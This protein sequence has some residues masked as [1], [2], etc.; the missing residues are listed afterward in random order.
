LP[1][2]FRPGGS[3]ARNAGK[4]AFAALA[5][6]CLTAEAPSPT[7][8][9][10]ANLAYEFVVHGRLPGPA[11]WK[12]SRGDSK[13]FVLGMP[14]ALPKGMTW[15]TSVLER[16]LKGANELIGRPQVRAG[17]G[18]LFSILK[19]RTSQPMEAQLSPSLRARLTAAEARIG[20]N[21]DAYSH[22]TPVVAGLQLVGDYRKSVALDSAEPGATIERLARREGIRV[23]PAGA[24]N[25]GALL[26]TITPELSAL[27]EI[28][29][30][31]ALDEVDA[32]PEQIRVAAE[33]W[34]KGDPRA[35]LSASR[36]YEKCVNAMPEGADLARRAMTDTAASIE[37]ALAKPG[38]AIAIVNLRTLLA[39]DG[40]LQQLRARGYTVTT[41]EE[42]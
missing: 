25:A 13:V 40:V 28:C 34:A 30:T 26:K 21:S 8:D 7:A 9:P 11:W 33:G 17:L 19:L 1:T 6:V 31:D 12:V 20:K 14:G 5:I 23:E 39:T 38:H 29:M 36:G 10:E 2:V 35:A 37:R 15:D 27:G 42:D 18:D 22:W 16:R 24:Y 3:A 32:G 4:G 41:P